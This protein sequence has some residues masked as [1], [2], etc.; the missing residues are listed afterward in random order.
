MVAIVNLHR[1]EVAF[2][3]VKS[4]VL[5]VLGFLARADLELAGEQS[6]S[7]FGV[8]PQWRGAWLEGGPGK[9]PTLLLVMPLSAATA[10]PWPSGC[11]A[12]ALLVLRGD[13]ASSISNYRSARDPSWPLEGAFGTYRQSP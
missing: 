5:V 9:P 11:V 10:S 1:R 8:T 7:R 3:T 12:A 6:L 13:G 4:Y 2:T